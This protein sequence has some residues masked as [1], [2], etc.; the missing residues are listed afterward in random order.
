[1]KKFLCFFVLLVLCSC[2]DMSIK[3]QRIE[4]PTDCV[5]NYGWSWNDGVA[6][7]TSGS[8][9][10]FEFKSKLSGILSFKYAFLDNY[11]S[12]YLG[13]SI[14][15]KDCFHEYGYD[16]DTIQVVLKNI[17]KNSTITFE[18]YKCMVKD[19]MISSSLEEEKP[20]DHT[21]PN[22]F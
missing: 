3:V 15:G 20:E 2:T 19:L 4:T 17:S 1:M 22:D 13:V 14:D 8:S 9:C 11:S 12:S 7:V 5:T 16:S 10:K 6:I 18:G 21:S